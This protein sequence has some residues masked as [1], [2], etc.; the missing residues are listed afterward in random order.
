M[1]LL[2]NCQLLSLATVNK[3]GLPEASLCPYLYHQGCFWV[4]VSRLSRHTHNLLQRPQVSVLVH[5]SI[6][7]ANNPY[8]VERASLHCDAAEVLADK[9]DILDL[10]T[11]KLGQT[12]TLLRQ[13][14]DF[15]LIQLR[16]QTGQF[17]AGFG[18]AFEINVDDLSLTHVRTNATDA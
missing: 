8:S 15:H 14:G 1:A 5:Q 3:Q 7:Q 10:M 11:A 4:F 9:A 2:E 13:L 17:V 18:R 6:E 16:P 12:L